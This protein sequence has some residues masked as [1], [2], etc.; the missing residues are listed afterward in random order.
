MH[1]SS[2]LEKKLLRSLFIRISCRFYIFID[3]SHKHGR[4]RERDGHLHLDEGKL[5]ATQ[6]IMHNAALQLWD[7]YNNNI[8]EELYFWTLQLQRWIQAFQS[9]FSITW[10]FKPEGYWKTY[11]ASLAS[12]PE[13]RLRR[14]SSTLRI[15][16]RELLSTSIKRLVFK[17]SAIDS[18]IPAGEHRRLQTNDQERIHQGWSSP[19]SFA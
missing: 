3:D 5:T 11:L 4:S 15:H 10:R 6:A 13:K 8:Q 14:L 2:W 16:K 1:C 9:Y 18:A 17:E 19:R 12:K 7:A